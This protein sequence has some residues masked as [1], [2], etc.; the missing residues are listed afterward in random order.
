[1]K[2]QVKNWLKQGKV[3]VFLG[4]KM[5]EGHPLPHFF[6]KERLEELE[7]MVTGPTRYPLEKIAMNLAAEDPKI[8][9]GLPAREC[10]RRA[11]NVLFLWHQLD[12]ERIETIPLACCPSQ[13]TDRADCSLL[14]HEESGIFKRTVGIDNHMEEGKT[15]AYD[16][17]ERFSRWR[18]EF[19]KC[20]KC[21]GCRDICPV[22]FCKE[23]SLEHESLIGTGDLPVEAPIFH[24][25]RSVHM[26]GRCIDCGLC[27]EACPMD[28]P[29]RLLYRM[30]NRIVMDVFD[31]RAGMNSD[32][33]PFNLLGDEVTLEPK[34]LSASQT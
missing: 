28:I 2:D 18:Y 11:L 5:V 10:N 12:P 7:D 30:V 17:E 15:G 25:V 34:S 23:C 9:I 21:Y 24:L 4:Y 20:I 29:L 22:C 6:V 31:Y 1:M 19:E 27:E 3:D 26:A 16:Q 13:L 14:K 32:Q 8:R 33:S